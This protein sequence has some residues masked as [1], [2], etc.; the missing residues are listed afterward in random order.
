MAPWC[1]PLTLQPNQSGGMG[2]IPGR[3]PP[4]ERLDKGSQ[5]RL[6]LLYFCVPALGTENRNFTFTSPSPMTS[7]CLQGVKN[8]YEAASVSRMKLIEELFFNR[9]ALYQ[10]K[11]QFLSIY[12]AKFK[13]LLQL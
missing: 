8:V 13:C 3:T 6:G 2:S 7:F 9:H 5:T 10:S 4:H 1:N 11:R 12:S